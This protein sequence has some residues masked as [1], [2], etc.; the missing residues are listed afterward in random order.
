MNK[1]GQYFVVDASSS[2][3]TNGTI[4]ISNFK[5]VGINYSSVFCLQYGMH[6]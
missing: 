1:H 5:Q 3:S 4:K 2:V 6:L